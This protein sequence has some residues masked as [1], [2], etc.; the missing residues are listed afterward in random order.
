MKKRS[1]SAIWT[2]GLK[3]GKGTISTET[4]VLKDTAYSFS[5]RFEDAV[6]TNPEELLG[7]AH[8]SCF[9]MALS[10]QL[11]AAGMT[12]QRLAT[13]A[14]VTIDKQDGGFGITGI[15]LDLTA[16]IPGASAD[17][18]MKAAQAAKEGCPLSKALKAVPIT[19][20]AKLEP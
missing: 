18:F 1:A 13:T 3:D 12:A 8:A 5:T 20:D 10:G 15:H 2:G 11:G 14:I 7:A 17:A 4:G 6:G 19:M 9:T 16:K